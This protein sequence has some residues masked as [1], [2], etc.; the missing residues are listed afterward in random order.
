MIETYEATTR[1]EVWLEATRQLLEDGN[2]QNVILHIEEPSREHDLTEEIFD[3]LD[4][5]YIE[6]DMDPIHTVS[7]WIFPA[8]MYKREGLEDVFEQYPEQIEDIIEQSPGFNWGTYFQR[9]ID[10]KDPETGESFNPLKNL[11]EKMEQANSPEGHPFHSCYELDLEGA[12]FGLST[13][14]PAGDRNRRRN[15]PCLSHLSFKLIDGDVH[16]TALY[17]SHDY[18]FKTL[19]NL[20]GLARLQA[21]VANEVGAGT[22]NL[23]VHS[24]RAIISGKSGKG[25]FRDLVDKFYKKM[26]NSSV[27]DF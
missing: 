21:C 7:E 15:L 22:G 19:G 14:D 6:N 16:L 3:S 24:S 26:K 4:E 12:D 2:K 20:L 8:W 10:R 23:V 13:Y 9:M 5:L 18:R 1:T 27:Q 25:E 11:I 17:R